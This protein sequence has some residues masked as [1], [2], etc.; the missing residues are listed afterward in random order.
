MDLA[1]GWRPLTHNLFPVAKE[2]KQNLGK[3]GWLSP[4]FA[5]GLPQAI[6]GRNV[7]RSV[8]VLRILRSLCRTL[9][10]ALLAPSV[11]DLS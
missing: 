6:L 8:F 9:F 1:S 2:R 4:W 5:L 7:R 11:Q 3:V 10:V